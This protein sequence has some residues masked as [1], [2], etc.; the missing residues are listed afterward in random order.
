MDR[1]EFLEKLLLSKIVI[2]SDAVFPYSM[3]IDFAAKAICGG[4][5]IFYEF[6]G[7]YLTF[8]V[9]KKLPFNPAKGKFAGNNLDYFVYRNE[10][11][12]HICPCM[13]SSHNSFLRKYMESV[14]ARRVYADVI[15]AVYEDR[16]IFNYDLAGCTD[17]YFYYR[18]KFKPRGS[19][20]EKIKLG[21][22][23][24]IRNFLMQ[25]SFRRISDDN[26]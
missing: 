23:A 17:T 2:D 3:D 15:S 18:V 1:N 11:E 13:A 5:I 6:N 25:A 20:I 7:E 8:F 24:Y 4:D 10:S 26:Q 14:S 12:S 19:V 9:R 22:R 16:R 21:G